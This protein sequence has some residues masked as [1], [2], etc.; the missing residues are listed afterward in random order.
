MNGVDARL[1][2]QPAR[3][4]T[5]SIRIESPEAIIVRHPAG[6][7]RKDL[8]EILERKRRWIEKRIV[9]LKEAEGEG[10]GR[11]IEEGRM[12]YVKGTP[13]ELAYGEGPVRISEGKLIV[14]PDADENLLDA[15]YGQ[16]TVDMAYKF[17]KR[18]GFAKPDFTIKVKKQKRI[19]GSCSSRRRI[20]INNRLS[21]CPSGVFDYVLWHEVCHLKHMDHSPGFY[22]ELLKKCPDYRECKKWLKDN[23]AKLKF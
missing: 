10:F 5:L 22:S 7:S 6:I 19:W 3:R 20:N 2:F 16:K 14:P 17:L 18:N 15:W 4:K 12:L 21:M 8:M 23:A 9:E 1:V 13:L 11:G